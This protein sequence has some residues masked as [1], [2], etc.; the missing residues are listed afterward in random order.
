[1]RG[2]IKVAHNH[3]PQSYPEKEPLSFMLQAHDEM[4]SGTPPYKRLQWVLWSV[5]ILTLATIWLSSQWHMGTAENKSVHW[6]SVERRFEHE[7]TTS[8]IQALPDHWRGQGH[9]GTGIATYHFVT[10]LS[11][12]EA[13][14]SRDRSW[15]LLFS[16]LS[17]EHRI[18]LNGILLQDTRETSSAMGEPSPTLLDVPGHALRA[19]TNTLEITVNARSRGGITQPVLAPAQDIRQAHLL[20]QMWNVVVPLLLNLTNITFSVFMIALWW[21]RPQE[22]AVA[23]FGL[24]NIVVSIRNCCYYLPNELG[25]PGWLSSWLFFSAHVASVTLLGWFI[26]ALSQSPSKT[27]SRLLKGVFVGFPLVALAALPWD[28]DLLQTRTWLQGPLILLT[29]PSLWMLWRFLRHQET[30]TLMGLLVGLLA[31]VMAG[32]HDYI[33][34]RLIQHPEHWNWMPWAI[35]LATPAFGAYLLKRIA[36]TFSALEHLNASLEQQVAERTHELQQANLAKSRFLAAASHD[37][38]QPVAAIGLMT[39]LLRQQTQAPA[40]QALTNKLSAAVVSMEEQLNGLLDLSRLDAGDIV[41][42]PQA[43]PLAPL[44][45][46][47]LAHVQEPA[48]EKALSL[49]V[50]AGDT[51][52]WCDPVLL[53][54]VLRNLVGNA[55]RHTRAGGV[56]IAVRPRAARLRIEV[57]DTGPGIAEA[58]Q[59]RVF[60][61]FVQLPSNAAAGRGLGLGLAIARRAASLM[62]TTLRLRSRPGR[63]SCFSL[64][65]PAL[66]DTDTSTPSAQPSRSDRPPSLLR[67]PEQTEATAPSARRVLLVED[68]APLRQALS[69]TLVHWGWEVD[70]HASVQAAQTQAQGPWALVITDHHLPDGEGGDVLQWARQLQPGVPSIVITGDTAPEQLRVLAT[71]D[72]PVLH[73]PFRPEKLRAMIGETMALTSDDSV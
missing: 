19:G 44:L 41:V 33:N 24:L 31:I 65:L 46:S 58:D 47:I 9:S 20:H 1:M 18:V 63:G 2:W 64:E 30:R 61:E 11:K 36:R 35:P 49:R 42:R 15:G 54:Q 12:D 13:Q 26:L 45:Q 4:T 5:L 21:N 27:W 50:R 25:I 16:A 28:E 59:Q 6:A 17:G 66:L 51:V 23:L 55:V 53:E 39:E 73:K 37:L 43:V 68:E 48:R 10:E 14:D 40:Q 71:L 70:A 38:R 72:A 3:T 22:H 60:D 34:A 67:T 69:L 62:G 29:L 32:A 7:S 8:R 57:W 52:A 56:L